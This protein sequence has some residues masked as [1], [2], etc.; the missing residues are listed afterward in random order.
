MF[1]PTLAALEYLHDRNLVHGCLKPSNV[2]AV[3]P[4]LK[5]AVD[6]VRRSARASPGRAGRLARGSGGLQR[7]SVVANDIW[8][9]G[10]LLIESL[11]RQRSSPKRP[12]TSRFN[13]PTRCRS[14]SEHR[15]RLLATRPGK[16]C[17]MQRSDA[18]WSGPA[19]WRRPLRWSCRFGGNSGQDATS[20][21]E[22]ATR[23]MRRAERQSRLIPPPSEGTTA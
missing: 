14:R 12:V 7:R 11:T 3:G 4:Q 15:A 19:R 9:L 22:T 17:S 23:Q 10:L 1:V 13:Y 16:R 6:G 21:R 5:L 8:A 2:M 18:C 20:P